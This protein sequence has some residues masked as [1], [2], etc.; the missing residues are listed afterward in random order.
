MRFLY[1]CSGKGRAE[2]LG[3]SSVNTFIAI[4][5][6]FALSGGFL[7]DKVIGTN[8]ARTLHCTILHAQLFKPINIL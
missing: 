5:Q 8:E 7:A 6:L 1:V 4:Y 2:K 3:T